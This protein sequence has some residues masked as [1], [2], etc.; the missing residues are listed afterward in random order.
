MLPFADVQG[1]HRG[2]QNPT[3]PRAGKVAVCPGPFAATPL[4]AP[5]GCSER[6]PGSWGENE[7]TSGLIEPPQWPGAA[8]NHV[9]V[10]AM[11]GAGGRQ[12]SS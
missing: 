3:C 9:A 5:R 1:K 4:P 11:K 8:I 10:W 7:G 6:E 12:D 2:S